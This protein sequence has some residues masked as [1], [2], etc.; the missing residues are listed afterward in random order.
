MEVCRAN[1][2]YAFKLIQALS[3]F[4]DPAIMNS[5]P[6][7]PVLLA[8]SCSESAFQEILIQRGKTP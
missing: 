7:L 3:L 4:S 8:S 1:Q 6:V 2:D 5:P